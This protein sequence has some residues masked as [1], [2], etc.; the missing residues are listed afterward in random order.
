MEDLE[1]ESLVALRELEGGAATWRSDKQEECMHAIMKLVGAQHLICVLPTGAGESILFMARAM[2]RGRGTSAVIVPF[3]TL[4][5]DLVERAR[6]KG[7]DVL[8]FQ[9]SEVVRREALPH[10]PRLVK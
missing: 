4:I 8:H 6:E 3:S 5:D 1:R 7:V 10:M 2:M 9:N